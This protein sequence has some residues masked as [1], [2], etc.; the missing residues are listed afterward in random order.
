MPRKKRH[1]RSFNKKCHKK[2]GVGG[3]GGSP[4]EDRWY[5]YVGTDRLLLPLRGGRMWAFLCGAGNVMVAQ[6]A[7]G[8]KREQL[9]S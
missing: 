3:G 5:H 1:G 2:M 6:A 8:P 9:L 4:I 7:A